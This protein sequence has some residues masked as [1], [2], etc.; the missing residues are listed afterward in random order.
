MIIICRSVIRHEVEIVGCNRGD[1]KIMNFSGK[2]PPSP[3]VLKLFCA[4]GSFE[5]L[6]KL[7][8][9]F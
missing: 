7:T 2:I 1:I 4:K 5:S 6:V 3:G 9:P 8:N